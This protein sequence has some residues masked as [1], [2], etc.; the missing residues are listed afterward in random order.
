MRT[1]VK[2]IGPPVLKAIKVLETIAVEIPEVCIMNTI[3]SLEIPSNLRKD[4]GLNIDT[5]G[6]TRIRDPVILSW[7]NDY[8]NRTGIQVQNERCKTIISE[9]GITEKGTTLGEYDFFFEWYKTPS[10]VQINNLVG[11]IDE[12]FSELGCYYSLETGK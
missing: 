3:I 11:M 8:F 9:S 7:V 4:V 10:I 2:I 6:S 1:Y 5:I 12:A